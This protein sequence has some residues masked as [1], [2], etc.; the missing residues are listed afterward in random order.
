MVGLSVEIKLLRQ[1]VVGDW[2]PAIPALLRSVEPS[3]E[4]VFCS[5]C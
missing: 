4:L 5:Y 3:D 2:A 1:S